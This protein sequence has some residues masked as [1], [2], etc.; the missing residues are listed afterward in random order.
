MMLDSRSAWFVICSRFSFV[1]I[2]FLLSISLFAIKAHC[3]PR[4]SLTAG[5]PCSGCHFSPN[6]GGGRTELGWGSMNKVGALTY[7]SLGL[8]ALHNQKSNQKDL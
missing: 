4:Q 3:T 6:G 5:T 8:S 7:D 2:A 1:I